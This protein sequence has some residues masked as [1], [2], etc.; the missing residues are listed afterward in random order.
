TSIADSGTHYLAGIR[1]AVETLAGMRLGIVFPDD[2]PSFFE[3]FSA[4]KS[5]DKKIFKGYLDVLSLFYEI[6]RR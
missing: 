4:E 6:K 3:F 1:T 5:V 2:E